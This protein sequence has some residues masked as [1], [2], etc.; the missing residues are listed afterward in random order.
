MADDP[1]VPDLYGDGVSVGTGPFGV[2]LTI[3]RSEP[4]RPPGDP[5]IPGRIVGH[6]RMSPELARALADSITKSLEAIPQATLVM[7]RDEGSGDDP[8]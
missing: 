1:T 4:L 6:V 8:S 2:T 5:G 3:F 7:E